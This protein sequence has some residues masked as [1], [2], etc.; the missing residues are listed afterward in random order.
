MLGDGGRWEDKENK[1]CTQ[2]RGNSCLKKIYVSAV[3]Y[4]GLLM[5]PV[6]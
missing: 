5:S 3:K 1:V 2:A 4:Y 6:L